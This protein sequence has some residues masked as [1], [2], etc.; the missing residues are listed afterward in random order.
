MS[1]DPI[2]FFKA[3]NPGKTLVLSNKRDRQYYTNFTAART[4]KQ[5]AISFTDELYRTI[6]RSDD[7]SYHLFTGHIGCGKST[8]LRKLQY[9]LEQQNYHVVYLDSSEDLVMNDVDLSDILLTIARQVTKS[10]ADAQIHID[11]TGFQGLLQRAWTL[12]NRDVDLSAEGQ[13]P[14]LGKVSASTSGEA[15]LDLGIAKL[16]AKLRSSSDARTRLRQH[17]EPQTDNLIQL[18]NQELLEPANKALQ[19]QGK[20]GLVV[21]IDSL[22]RLE[23]TRDRNQSE[24]I[25][26]TRGEKLRQFSCHVV[27]TLPLVLTFS[28]AIGPLRDRFG[29]DP[30]VLPM[31]RVCDRN[32]ISDD[33][34]ISLLRRMI[35]SRA[36]PDASA[37]EQDSQLSQI[38]DQPETCDRLCQVSGGHVR[39]LLVMLFGCLQKQD[40]PIE[41]DTL[42]DVILNQRDSYIRAIDAQEWE[43]LHQVN[44]QKAVVGEAG[45]QA[46]LKSLFVFEYRDQKGTWFGLNPILAEAEQFQ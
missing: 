12:L 8:E 40:P 26:I 33:D 13:L 34:G 43:L 21:I 41:R 39:N 25:F 11:P 20:N 36:F 22:D 16:S 18:I 9:D 19:A 4:S 29:S 32:G 31:V 15:A 10:L 2:L 7:R 37:A 3:C 6:T 27:Y 23:N 17:L 30:K 28:N 38:F 45:Y 1:F 44:A 14:G 5:N 35:S 24:Y 42:E 46:L